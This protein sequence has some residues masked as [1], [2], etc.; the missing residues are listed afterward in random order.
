MNKQKWS[1]IAA[2][3]YLSAIFG[4]GRI[5]VGFADLVALH[6][7]LYVLVFFALT[8]P[9]IISTLRR[10]P[11]YAVFLIWG[12]LL[13]AGRLLL[14]QTPLWA[15]LEIYRTI[16]ELSLIAIAAWLGNVIAHSFNEM[17]AFIEAVTLPRDGQRI[18]DKGDSTDEIKVEFIRSRRHNRPLS[19]IMLEP[20][21]HS[22]RMD[23]ERILIE[24]QNKMA[25][26][27]LV[28]SLAEIINKEVRRTD[29]IVN[30]GEDGRFVV[31][32]PE[33]TPDGSVFLAERI[34]AVIMDKLN[35]PMAFGSASFPDQAVTFEDLVSH[36]EFELNHYA[37][38]PTLTAKSSDALSQKMEK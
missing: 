26:R 35:I 19:I 4:L 23:L 29:I 32:C 34:Q 13:L 33:T 21:S 14:G 38:L 10:A 25:E 9:L 16:T 24:I 20:A 6:D 5:Q 12:G 3:L 11:W 7:I 18:L 30:Q 8:T 22:L 36:A 27:F 28:A 37:Q 31:L 15:A 2:L 1:L 17:E